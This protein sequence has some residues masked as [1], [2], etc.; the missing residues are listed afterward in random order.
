[1]KKLLY[2]LR[3]ALV[4]LLPLLLA[5]A[6][7]MAQTI[8]YKGDTTPL[9]V[10]SLP[11]DSYKWEIYSDSTVNFATAPADTPG[12]TF[13]FVGGNEKAKVN[14][15]WLAIGVYFFK[16][17]ATNITGCTNNLRV[18]II[19]VIEPPPTAVLVLKPDSVCIGQWAPLEITFAGRPPWNFKLQAE[20]PLGNITLTDYTGITD[21]QNPL[22]IPLNP[23]VTTRYM[24]I[25]LNDAI[26]VQKKPSNTVD[27][28]I[29]PLPVSS[30]IYLKTP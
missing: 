5:L 14:V 9:A 13:A 19:K 10:D 12:T 3:P 8:V 20:D 23:A 27:L 30:R 29:H 11:G 1:M 24:V 6:P 22:I 17:T 28:T 26:S 7:A 2:I 4:V 25:G 15:K 18:G 16:V 21:L